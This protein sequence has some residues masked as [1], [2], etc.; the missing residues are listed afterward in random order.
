MPTLR[1]NRPWTP[2]GP[3]TSTDAYGD[4]WTAYDLDFLSGGRPLISPSVLDVRRVRRPSPRAWRHSGDPAWLFFPPDQT[5]SAGAEFGN[6]QPGPGPYTE[7]TF[8]ERL[9]QLGIPY[10]VVKL[11]ILDAVVPASRV[12][13]P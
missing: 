6:P 13:T 11:G 10:R 12:T 9:G 4:Y 2:C 3:I 1:C 5:A 7:Q 8:E